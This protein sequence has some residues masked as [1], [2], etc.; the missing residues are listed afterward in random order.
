MIQ[1]MIPSVPVTETEKFSKEWT[2]NGIAITLDK[3]ALQFA[4][5]WANVLLRQY[6]IGLQQ[7]LNQQAAQPK[8]EASKEDNV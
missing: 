3:P 5:D 6:A 8:E 7:A 1:M 4:T 2:Y